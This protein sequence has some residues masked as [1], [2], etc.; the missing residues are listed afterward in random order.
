MGL[1]AE[2]SGLGWAGLGQP[3]GLGLRFLDVQHM[4]E[5]QLEERRAR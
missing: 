2:A 5:A 3:L 1:R 4:R